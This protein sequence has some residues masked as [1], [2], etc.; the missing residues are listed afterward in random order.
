MIGRRRFA[1]FQQ[2][3]SIRRN[4]RGTLG[5]KQS[6]EAP[7]HGSMPTFG[8]GSATRY[9]RRSNEEDTHGI[10]AS[11][12]DCWLFRAQRLRNTDRRDKFDRQGGPAGDDRRRTVS[13]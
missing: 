11:F 3:A 9:G 4:P 6:S 5:L 8:V 13:D 1:E 7:V 12:R 2:V 10:T